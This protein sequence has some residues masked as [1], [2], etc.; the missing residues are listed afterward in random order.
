LFL[1]GIIYI[2]LFV[3]V[4]FVVTIPLTSISKVAFSASLTTRL[5]LGQHQIVE[6]DKVLTNIG[7]GYDSRHGHFTAPIKAVYLFSCSMMNIQAMSDAYLE[8]V[9]NGIRVAHLYSDKDDFSMATQ[10]VIVL[11]EKGD[12]VW[13]RHSN[14]ASSQSLHETG[15]NTFVGTI[16]F[17]I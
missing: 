14:T 15:Y 9:K 10:V 12:M 4:V 11:L 5:A 16:L 7:N 17:E 6:Y 1:T 3:I 8:I 13:V 2:I